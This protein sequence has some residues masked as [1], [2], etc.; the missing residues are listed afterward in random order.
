MDPKHRDRIAFV[1]ICSGA[2]EPGMQVTNVRTGKDL[3]LTLPTQFM[4]R[5]RTIVEEAWAGDVIGIHDRGSL[6]IGDTLSANGDAMFSGIPRFS[7]EHFARVSVPDP[8]RRKH[9]DTGLR[10]LSEEGAVQVFYDEGMT[11]PSPIVG[12]VGPLQFEVLLHRLEHEYGVKATLS[13]LPYRAARWLTGDDAAIQEFV[14]GYG[15][16]R[17]HDAK[18]GVLA[19]FESEWA[20][21][22]SLDKTNGV[23]LH[24]VA[25]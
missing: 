14:R 19:L 22:N 17:V 18:G 9:L 13:P 15:R 7:P 6:R 1:R 24:E 21:M 11:G 8:L 5:E 25:P 16:V 10:Q 4:A 3:R 12:A 23:T 2:Y 20:L